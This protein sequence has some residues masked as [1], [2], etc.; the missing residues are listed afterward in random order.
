MSVRP[1]V[2]LVTGGASGIGLEVARLWSAAGHRVVI[3]D[4]RAAAGKAATHQLTKGG[5]DVHFVEADLA[6]DDDC[7]RLFER[8]TREYGRLDLALNNAGIAGPAARVGEVAPEAWR[9]AI[10]INLFGVFRCLAAELRIFATQGSGCAINVSS[11]YGRR[12]VA[13]GSAYAASKHAILGLTRSAAME[14]GAQGIRVNAVCPGFIDTPFTT[15]TGSVIPAKVIEAQ[16]RRTAARRRGTPQEVA[17][18][19]AWLSTD[20][21]SYINGAAIDIDGGFLAT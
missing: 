18:A 19:I 17:Q 11:V 13:G 9:Q 3:T 10:E 21:A 1:R 20:A 14:Y 2:A 15:A 7:L 16:I 4:V 5:A 8:I 6:R 12:G